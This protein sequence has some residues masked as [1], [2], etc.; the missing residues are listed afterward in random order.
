M[1]FM[2]FNVL[3]G[4]VNIAV[5]LVA[6]ACVDRF[7]RRPLLIA[8]SAAMTVCLGAVALCFA[9]A[10]TG[11]DGAVGLSGSSAVIALSAANGFVVAFGAS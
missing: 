9:S 11:A 3:T 5:T 2:L 7:G 10:A 6:I 8:G 4:I 1:V